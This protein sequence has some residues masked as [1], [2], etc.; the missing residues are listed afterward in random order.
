MTTSTKTGISRKEYFE[1]REAQREADKVKAEEAQID[2]YKLSIENYTKQIKSNNALAADLR[3][4]AL[5]NADL[6]E[7]D[8]Y[9]Q[10][11]LTNAEYA[12]S[13]A[14]E[15]RRDSEQR[16]AKLQAKTAGQAEEDAD[17]EY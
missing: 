12:S 1:A 10:R 9:F 7:N 14:R 2:S 15:Y 8:S 4:V 5:R 6:T 3:A 17:E 11:V 13:S 16:L